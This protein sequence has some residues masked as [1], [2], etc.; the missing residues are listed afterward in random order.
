MQRPKFRLENNHQGRQSDTQ[1][2]FCQPE[3][4]I[5]LKDCCNEYKQQNH[6]DSFEQIPRTRIF[7][8][9]QNMIKQEGNDQYFHDIHK[10]K[11]DIRHTEQSCCIVIKLA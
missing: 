1:R 4:G 2:I 11:R 8:P 5:H 7:N 10:G 9:K 6:D 3:D